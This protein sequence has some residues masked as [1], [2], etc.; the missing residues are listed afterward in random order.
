V[1]FNL[2]YGAALSIALLAILVAHQRRPA[3]AAAR[4]RGTLMTRWRRPPPQQA[5]SGSASPSIRP[6]IIASVLFLAPFVMGGAG[7]VQATAG[8]APAA[9]AALADTGISARF[10]SLAR[11]LRRRHLAAHVNS[12]YR[13]AD[14]R[15]V[16]RRR[17]PAGR[18]RLFAL[19]V[20]VQERASSS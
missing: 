16:D 2:G 18:L 20:S 10:L 17:Q 19:P 13:F 3:L 1:S 7:G 6:V 4:R 8:S 9:A 14:D 5:S 15:G 11:Q 12:L